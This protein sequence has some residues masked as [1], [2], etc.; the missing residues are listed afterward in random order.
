VRIFYLHHA[1]FKPV[2]RPSHPPR[3]DHSNNFWWKVQTMQLLMMQFFPVSVTSSLLGPNIPLSAL[4]SNT[5]NLRSSLNVR[6][7]VSHLY[8]TSSIMV[9]YSPDIHVFT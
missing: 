7:Q 5:L 4:F 8:K 6:E 3:F 9:L 2:P 1:R